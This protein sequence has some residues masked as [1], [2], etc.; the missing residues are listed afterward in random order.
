MKYKR[1]LKNQ[2][3]KQQNWKGENNMKN[4]AIAT[5][6]ATTIACATFVTPAFATNMKENN[7]PVDVVESV[8]IMP[9][10]V[11]IDEG[12]KNNETGLNDSY[13]LNRENGKYV[14]LYVENKGSN[15]VVA[16][17]ND[18]N[19]KTFKPGAKGHI[20]VEVTQGIFGGDKTYT[21]KVVAGKNGGNV[22]IHYSIAQ[23]DTK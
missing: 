4:Q 17:I 20:S 16:T 21:F 8:K 2:V 15:D 3:V 5:L 12:D 18:T 13:K 11:S 6:L 23:R 22:N 9:R 7:H 1:H 19:E 14:N 10:D